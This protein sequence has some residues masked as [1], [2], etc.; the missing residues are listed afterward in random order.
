[1][2]IIS[3]ILFGFLVFSLPIARAED[4]ILKIG[5]QTIHAEIADT[6]ESRERG[7]M[8]RDHLCENCGML[9]IFEQADRYQFWMK[10][11]P[12][13]LSIAFIAT[14]GSIINIDEMLPN[15]TN[16]HDAHGKALYALEMNSGWFS[17]YNITA[18]D[19]VQGLKPV[20]TSD[21]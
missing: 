4:A 13:P 6:E 9:F 5:A 1:M 21:H 14:D 3:T 11:T 2:K 12:I 17:K 7:L 8:Q 10:N 19:K 15:T 18:S 20:Q 16:T